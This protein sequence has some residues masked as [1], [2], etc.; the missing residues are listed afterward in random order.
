LSAGPEAAVEQTAPTLVEV[1]VEVWSFRVGPFLLRECGR[2][3]LVLVVLA[4]LPVVGVVLR[5]GRQR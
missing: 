4:V 2:L 5:A 3:P 1:E